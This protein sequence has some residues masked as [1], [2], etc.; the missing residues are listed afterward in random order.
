MLASKAAGPVG[1]EKHCTVEE[2][3]VCWP[4]GAW[5]RRSAP[6][7][8]FEVETCRRLFELG[9]PLSRGGRAASV[10]SD[11]VTEWQRP[12]GHARPDS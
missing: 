3:K 5:Y 9:N 2:S 11:G 6:A 12:G 7:R 1:K 4:S 10:R 8:K